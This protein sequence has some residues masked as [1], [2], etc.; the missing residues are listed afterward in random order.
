M[1]AGVERMQETDDMEEY[2][3]ILL[4]YMTTVDCVDAKQL[5]LSAYVLQ[6]SSQ[7]KDLAWLRKGLWMYYI[8][9]RSYS[10]SG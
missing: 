5:W 10:S 8:Y 9:F 1:Q 4:Q 6:E 7:I 3:E 2:C